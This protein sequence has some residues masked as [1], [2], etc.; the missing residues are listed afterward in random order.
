MS[1]NKI[2]AWHSSGFQRSTCQ[3]LHKITDVRQSYTYRSD[4][5]LSGQMEVKD[6]TFE[7]VVTQFKEKEKVTIPFVLNLQ[8]IFGR[9][10]IECVPEDLTFLVKYS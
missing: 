3:V 10:V 7:V 5:N 9:I 4:I 2:E 6:M 1:T 8:R